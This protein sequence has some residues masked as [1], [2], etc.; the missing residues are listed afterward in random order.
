MLRFLVSFL[1]ACCVV[2]V[3]LVT[4]VQVWGG[5]E[6]ATGEEELPVESHPLDLLVGYDSLDVAELFGEP[7]RRL[8]VLEGPPPAPEAG[9]SLP[10]REVQGFVQVEVEVDERGRVVDARVLGATP[11]GIYDRRALARVRAQRFPPG[12][13]GT[14]IRVVDFTLEAGAGP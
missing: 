10:A 1:A 2:S 14:R 12:E 8:P 3:M 13:P 7:R 6:R 5:F 11:S 9:P 4:A